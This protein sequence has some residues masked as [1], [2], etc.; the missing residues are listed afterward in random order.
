VHLGFLPLWNP[1]SGPGLPLAFNW[2]SASFGVPSL[3]GYL[4]PFP[5]HH[6]IELHYWPA[7]FALGLA[8]A[9]AAVLALAGGLIVD[10][11]ARRRRPNGL[12]GGYREPS[13]H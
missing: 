8:A 3:I 7:A 5:G 10:H 9:L 6:V 4:M 2:Q 12:T 13:P 1:Y 11:R